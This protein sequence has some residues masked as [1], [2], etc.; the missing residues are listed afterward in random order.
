VPNGTIVTPGS[1]A[2]RTEGKKR[3]KKAT[4]NDDFARAFTFTSS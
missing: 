3:D 2:A 4:H 1:T